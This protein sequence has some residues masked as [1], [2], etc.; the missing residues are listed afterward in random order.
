MW[1]SIKYSLS[2]IFIALALSACSTNGPD[3]VIRMGLTTAPTNLDPRFATDAIS[4][5]INRLLYRQLV[6]FDPTGMPV[7]S[8]ASWEQLTPTHYRFTLL[9]GGRSF[10]HGRK[11][12][13]TDVKA[14]F[15]SIL[16]PATASPHRSTINVIQNIS[17]KG[18]DRIDFFLKH[19]DS[20]FPGYL[21]IGILPSDLMQKEHPF[22]TQPIGSGPFIFS[23]WPQPGVARLTRIKDRQLFEFVP[24]ADP[25]VR[26]LKLLRGE[27]DMLQ[28]DLPPEL[29]EYLEGREGVSVIKKPGNNFSYLG[30]NLQDRFTGRLNIRRAIAHAIDREAIIKYF[31]NDGAVLAQA[32]L[33]PQHWAGAKGLK[34]YGFDPQRARLLLQQA[35][36]TQKNPLQLTYKTST[37]PFRVRLATV[38][39]SQLAQVG[40]KLNI[41][42]HDWGTFYGDVKSGRFQLYSLSWVG[43]KTPDIFRYV[44]HSASVPPNGANRGR[45]N[46]KVIDAII[47]QA[48]ATAD[49][50]KKA[51]LYQRMQ[52]Q[53]LTELPYIPLWYED[54]VFI[55][56]DYITGYQ[57]ASDGNYDGLAQ[58]QS[59]KR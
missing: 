9:N 25:S 40:I 1:R 33:P 11:L 54:H 2:S 28:N 21:S 23:G 10:H 22:S 38:I 29:V 39:Q 13:A 31:L 36:F 49:F 50:S 41:H 47:S 30:F 24:V 35:G 3:D 58:V 18:D 14:T 15:D 56:R 32:L 17:V 4:S 12:I 57:L 20:L 55:S 52:Q 5:R 44:F 27:I 46:S 48:E 42:S 43:I 37:D 59:N 19:P 51:T 45:F 6:A 34:P 16:D 53:L 7:P 8:L 26:V